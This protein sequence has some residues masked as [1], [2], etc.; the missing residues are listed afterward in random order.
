MKAI[1]NKLD[2]LLVKNAPFQLPENGRKMLVSALP[3]LTL[4]GGVLS[5]LAVWGV[6]QLATW[7]NTWM[8]AASELGTTYGYAGY[9]GYASN[10]PLL[11]MSAILIAVEAILFFMAFSPLKERRK[12]GWDLL[13]W[14]SMLNVVYAVVYMVATP[15]LL[16]LIFSLLGSLV[17][18]YLLFQ[19]RS[20]YTSAASA[21]SS[22]AKKQQ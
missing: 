11:L 22:S 7:A 19:V 5:V 2:E 8:N 15:N 3:W 4:I 10:G 20:H 18:L 21:S 1:E 14:V 16:S 13:F 6:Y 9:S 17:G 12:R